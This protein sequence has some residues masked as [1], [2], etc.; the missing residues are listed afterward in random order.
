MSKAKQAAAALL[1]CHLAASL[2]IAPARAAD[3]RT[4]SIGTGI[5]DKPS[6]QVELVWDDAW[7]QEDADIYRQALALAAMTFSGTAYAAP[8]TFAGVG[9][10]LRLAG[11]D[12]VRAYHHYLMEAGT[13]MAAYTF[14]IKII[15]D[16][17]GG[18]IPLVAVVV[19]GTNEVMEWAGNLNLGYDTDHAGFRKA[20]DELLAN[21][22][23][24]L[25]SAGIAGE[26]RDSVKFFVTGHSR[27]GAAANLAAAHLTAKN[28]GA[29]KNVYAYTFAA[30][31]VSV[32]GTAEG[33]GNIFNII[34]TDDLVT[35]VPLAGWGYCRYGIDLLLPENND[36]IYSK[37]DQIYTNLTGQPYMPY[38]NAA[39]V[40]KI[41]AA[42]RTIAP[43]ANG[44]DLEMLSA[45]FSGDLDRLRTLIN[46]N[47]LAALLLGQKALTV[48]SSVMPLVELEA[49]GLV[50]AH[51]IAGYY[52]WLSVCE[53]SPP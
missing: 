53:L 37:M 10:A 50:S 30:P 36:E 38:R 5:P 40:Q 19:R 17:Q 39:A 28:P 26:A 8:G 4:V 9:D 43:T 12:Q 33:F 22:E 42:I 14:G 1:A 31:S 2:L 24:Y 25:I 16:R 41:V 45:L 3:D 21:L 49:K 48:S 32:N 11:F 23:Q 20:A 6:A 27:G 47:G 13:D 15:Q 44:T 51:C 18:E 52:S 35:Q 29:G 46:A 7:F 34:R